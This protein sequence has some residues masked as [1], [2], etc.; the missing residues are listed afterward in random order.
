MSFSSANEAW[1][2]TLYESNFRY[3]R[4]DYGVSKWLGIYGISK[5][6]VLD[7]GLISSKFSPFGKFDWKVEINGIFSISTRELDFEI[8]LH[9]LLI[10]F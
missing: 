10:W 7:F 8:I 5:C 6:N 4:L 3:N 9:I 2:I 1:M